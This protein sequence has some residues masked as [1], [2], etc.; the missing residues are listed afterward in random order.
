MYIRRKDL[1]AILEAYGITPHSCTKTARGL[2]NYNWIVDAGKNKY[3]LRG[4]RFKKRKE[5]EFEIKYLNYLKTHGFE[6]QIP[7]AV[8]SRA[9]HFVK[10]FSGINFW[11][12][13]YI[14]GEF[15]RHPERQELRAIAVM[16]GKYHT[17][18]EQ[19]QF[20]VSHKKDIIRM[21]SI[22]TGIK[23]QSNRL[24]GNSSHIDSLYLK[25][26]KIL[27]PAA[28]NLC[29]EGYSKLKRYPLHRDFG[30]R[31]FLWNGKQLTGIIDFEN[32][33]GP[34]EPLVRDISS[35]FQYHCRKRKYEMDLDMTRYFLAKYLKYRRI[36][37]MEIKLIPDLMISMYAEDFD[38]G[39]WRLKNDPKRAS[40]SEFELCAKSARWCA[41]N[42]DRIIQNLKASLEN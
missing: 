2:V 16:M 6:Y 30:M 24:R 33:S 40:A 14:D 28:E 15:K 1:N 38:F 34:A 36:T 42:S 39:Y 20:G 25:Y 32:V 4:S 9:G 10:E 17:I 11:V 18:L 8:R 23:R 5:L 21:N 31:N 13:T 35:F 29:L 22:I 26:S 37:A 27:V 41:A 19:S 3:I 7:S 12:Y